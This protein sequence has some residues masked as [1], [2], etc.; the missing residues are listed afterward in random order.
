MWMA[1]GKLPNFEF[2]YE[3]GASGTLESTVFSH[4]VPAWTSIVTGVNPGKHG[5]H[6]IFNEKGELVSSR[7]RKV[8]AIWN[9]LTKYR[10]LSVVINLPATYPAEAI[11]GIM[12]SGLLSPGEVGDFAYPTFIK[13]WLKKVGY[14]IQPHNMDFLLFNKDKLLEELFRVARK[15]EKVVFRILDIVDWDFFIAVFTLIDHLQHFFW[16]Y[17]DALSPYHNDPWGRKYHSAIFR[18]YKF[19]DILLGKLLDKLDDAVLFIVSD[20]GMMPTNKYFYINEWLRV[21]GFLKVKQRSVSRAL[22]DVLGFLVYSHIDKAPIQALLSHLL[23]HDIC[24]RV[25]GHSYK[26]R[27]AELVEMRDIDVN[28]SLAYFSPVHQGIIINTDDEGERKR[29]IEILSRDL[30][31]MNYNGNSVIRAVIER[32][33]AC[34][35]RYSRSAPDLYVIPQEG[36]DLHEMVN[37]LSVLFGPPLKGILLRTAGHAN[38]SCNGIFMAYNQRLIKHCHVRGPTV[39]DIT[40][41]VLHLLG[42]RPPAY[43]DGRVLTEI[44]T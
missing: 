17:M 34:W 20:H 33:K 27:R 44:L 11:R 28:T 5:L 22:K 16:H 38:H 15:R 21:R 39:Y 23:R 41:T 1:D 31:N 18:G 7:D 12:I 10:K 43:M 9:I 29:L 36:Y 30:L 35:G 8:E 24:F 42:I 14:K 6:G 13:P 19:M 32:E 2:V 3:K 40:P 4:S 26:R 25:F 37:N